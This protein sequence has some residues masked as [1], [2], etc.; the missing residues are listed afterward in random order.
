VG[1]FSHNTA[2][3]LLKTSNAL[4]VVQNVILTGF[5]KTRRG[6]LL[7]ARWLLED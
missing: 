4:K 1:Q 5:L 3:L 7:L 6:L 2:W